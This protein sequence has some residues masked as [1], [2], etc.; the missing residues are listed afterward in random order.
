MKTAS[1]W[2]VPCLHPRRKR[3]NKAGSSKPAPRRQANLPSAMSTSRVKATSIGR[4]KRG[5][6]CEANTKGTSPMALNDDEKAELVAYLD[7]ELDE[8]ATQAVE[9]RIAADPEAR[10][11]LEAMK[12]TWFM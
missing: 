11:E 2:A 5:S 3:G 8:T 6:R 4:W 10:A 7:G 12:Q 9:A 1:C